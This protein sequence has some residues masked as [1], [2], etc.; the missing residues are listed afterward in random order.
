[1]GDR[2]IVNE[3][4]DDKANYGELP[5][6]IIQQIFAYTVAYPKEMRELDIVC[7]NFKG[8]MAAEG[9]ALEMIKREEVC[10]SKLR[11]SIC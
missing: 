2:I 6:I 8:A 1:M 9:L 7:P 3:N 10:L 11:Q 5:V 4:S